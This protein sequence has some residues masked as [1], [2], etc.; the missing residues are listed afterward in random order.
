[1]NT[2][3]HVGQVTQLADPARPE[4][5][6]HRSALGHAIASEATNAGNPVSVIMA[7]AVGRK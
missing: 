6:A 2:T 3:K 5:Y 4:V 1:M 7:G